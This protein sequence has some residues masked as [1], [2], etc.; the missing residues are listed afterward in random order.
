M[1]LTGGTASFYNNWV[2]DIGAGN[3]TAPGLVKAIRFA[4]DGGPPDNSAFNGYGPYDSFEVRA[5]NN[6]IVNS[7]DDGLATYLSAA[8]VAGMVPYFYNN[9]IV[10]CGDRGILLNG[11]EGGWVRNNIVLGCA[12]AITLDG[13]TT[14]TSNLESGAPSTIFVAPEASNYHLASEQAASGSIGTDIAATD[15]AGT[16]R[17]GTASKGAYEFS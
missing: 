3:T 5:Y 11:T 15:Y 17:T 8:S 2:E 12:T 6:V 10:T 14:K 1:H 16:S 13:T 4:Q 7:A 9:T